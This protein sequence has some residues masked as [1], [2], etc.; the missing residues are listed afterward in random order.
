M[1]P[2]WTKIDSFVDNYI[3]LQK[4]GQEQQQ[5]DKVLKQ[6]LNSYTDNQKIITETLQWM[7]FFIIAYSER[8]QKLIEY[9]LDHGVK[10]N[11][12]HLVRLVV[13][14][15]VRNSCIDKE[16]IDKM[17][18]PYLLSPLIDT[19]Q[20]QQQQQ[21]PQDWTVELSFLQGNNANN[22][23]NYS[24]TSSNQLIHG[25]DDNN[26]GTWFPLEDAPPSHYQY[27]ISIWRSN[28]P[29][30]TSQKK[31]GNHEQLT[32]TLDSG[33]DNR[34]R[35]RQLKVGGGDGITNLSSLPIEICIFVLEY[36]DGKSF[37]A[38]RLASRN[39]AQASL[40]TNSGWKSL[41]LSR[42]PDVQFKSTD[43]ARNRLL[44]R[45]NK[46]MERKNHEE[47]IFFCRYCDATFSSNV[48][49]RRH[50]C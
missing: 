25:D 17:I 4:Y 18:T 21:Q 28:I 3:E 44:L 43:N 8:K 50:R 30:S 26:Q 35:I 22:K 40:F 36:C 46:E 29:S 20:Q 42:W 33:G 41:I 23:S 24:S 32:T 48:K 31:L 7:L 16:E 14:V 5:E 1:A 19:Q 39:L 10:N 37:L 34:K 47:M 2:N 49:R 9:L 15:L 45:I 11:L 13:A 6:I 27:F 38:L 12:K